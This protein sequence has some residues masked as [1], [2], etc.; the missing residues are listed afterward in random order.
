[1]LFP[2][3]LLDAPPMFLVF[4]VGK[5]TRPRLGLFRG[6]LMLGSCV[7]AAGGPFCSFCVLSF[8]LI[9]SARHNAMSIQ[10][11]Q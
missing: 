10:G 8:A 11:S 5:A 3:L 2:I 4:S 1:M 9:V 6:Y 7:D